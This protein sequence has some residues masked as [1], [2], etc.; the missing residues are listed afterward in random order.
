MTRTKKATLV[1]AA[2]VVVIAALG[3]AVLASPASAQT[4]TPSTT[5][6]S[7]G[8]PSRMGSAGWTASNQPFNWGNFQQGGPGMR[9]PSAFSQSQVNI[10]VGQAITITST[11]G[12]YFLV[13]TP[14]DNGTASGTLTFTVTGKLTAGYT[15]SLTGGSVTIGSTTY[16]LTSGTAQMDRGASGITGQGATTPA[17]QFILRATARG[18]FAG[19]TGSVSLDLMSGSSEYLVSLTGSISG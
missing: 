10:P 13:G 14:S 12:R 18:S 16:T 17:G 5:N 4:G 15:L 2:A 6:L 8:F 7:P 19:S 11:Q 1:L 9:G 3:Y